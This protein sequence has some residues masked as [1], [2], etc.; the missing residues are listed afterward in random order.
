MNGVPGIPDSFPAHGIVPEDKSDPIVGTTS[1]TPS[2]QQEASDPKSDNGQGTAL[3]KGLL[4]P[5]NNM[6]IPSTSHANELDPENHSPDTAYNVASKATFL[7]EAIE[8]G[9]STFKKGHWPVTVDGIVV[10]LAPTAMMIGSETLPLP[11]TQQTVTI[12]AGSPLVYHPQVVGNSGKKVAPGSSPESLSEPIVTIESS[13]VI[14]NPKSL[15]LQQTKRIVTTSTT[16]EHLITS[17]HE[18]TCIGRHQLPISVISDG[19]IVLE[20]SKLS[21]GAAGINV[22]VTSV[23]VPSG[24]EVILNG[25]VLIRGGAEMTFNG[26][27]INLA[28]DGNLVIGGTTLRSGA[29]T[30]STDDVRAMTTTQYSSAT[31]KIPTIASIVSLNALPMESFGDISTVTSTSTGNSSTTAVASEGRVVRSVIEL[32]LLTIA[33]LSILIGLGIS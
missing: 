1:I 17:C 23:S 19:N 29:A 14:F 22:S 8:I 30:P 24:S 2:A 9:S 18:P 13:D 31:D 6:G 26:I 5:F 20:M 32:S 27:H 15:S 21:A 28:S 12:I 25:T 33:T 16:E 10:S 3:L 11:R 7:P 4:D